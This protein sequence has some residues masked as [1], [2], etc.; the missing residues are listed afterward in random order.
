MFRIRR[1]YDTTLPINQA[2]MAHVQA[3]LREQ[4]PLLAQKEIDELPQRL[5]NPL[6]FRFRSILFVADDHKGRVKGFAFL[7][8]DPVLGFCYLDFISTASQLTGRGIGGALYERI[9]QEALALDVAGLFF[10]CL[11]D[12]PALCS[13]PCVLKQ[14]A[15]RLSFYERYGARPIAGTAYETP[16]KP[17]TDNPP[18]LVFDNLGRDRPLRRADARA[19]VRAILE[20][21]YGASCPPGYID[22]VEQSFRDDPVRVREPRYAKQEH[23]VP[24]H[25]PQDRKIALVVNDQH[26]IHH[27]R[28]Q[29]YVEAPI[30]ISAI[31]REIEPPGCSIPCPP[32]ISPMRSSRRSTI[33]VSSTTCARCAWP[34]IPTNPSIRTSSRSGTARGR[35][36]IWPCGPATIASTRSRR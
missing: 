19:I 4:F 28:D 17:D 33:P 26:S 32:A 34:S 8:H 27:V 12:D 36:R 7:F 22:K 30:R 11:P 18:Y 23:P 31:L 25:V 5:N 14:N 16:L 24:Q 9:R 20:R 10:E 1:L 35:R 6:K 13:D 15:A 21:Q 29:G 3:I 2:V